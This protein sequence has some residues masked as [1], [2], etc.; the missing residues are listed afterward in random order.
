[1]LASAAL[2]F[3]HKHTSL[4]SV[5][6][7]GAWKTETA[8][9]I[10]VGLQKCVDDAGDS[11]DVFDFYIWLMLSTE[12]ST[13]EGAQLRTA[14]LFPDTGTLYGNKMNKYFNVAVLGFLQVVVPIFLI[15]DE[16]KIFGIEPV[17]SLQDKNFTPGSEYC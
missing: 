7:T 4:L 8:Q 13:A 9:Q 17:H 2:W 12:A 1:V 16:I 6:G 14:K 10:V 15:I 3:D 5:Y 11:A